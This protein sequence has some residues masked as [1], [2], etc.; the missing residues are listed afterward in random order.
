[1]V[2][3]KALLGAIARLQTTETRKI[4]HVFSMTGANPNT[5]WLG[6]CVGVLDNKQLSRPAP[7][8]PRGHSQAARWPLQRQPYLFETS[9]PRVFAVGDVRSRSVKRVASA[10]GEG[11]RGAT[12]PLGPGMSSRLE[13]V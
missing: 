4:R 2:T 13:R 3:W 12:H 7:I 1:M 10:V 9:V 8:L 5:A 11:G 6:T